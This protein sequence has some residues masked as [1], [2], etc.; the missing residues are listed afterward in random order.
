M[1]T[2][3]RKKKKIDE[4]AKKQN[5]NSKTHTGVCGTALSFIRGSKPKGF[6]EPRPLDASSPVLL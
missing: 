4:L 2:K 6:L 3:K 1:K 5:A